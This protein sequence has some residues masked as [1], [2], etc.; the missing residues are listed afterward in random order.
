MLKWRCSYVCEC[1][2]GCTCKCQYTWWLVN[3]W[4]NMQN[5]L[6]V[7][8]KKCLFSFREKKKH[9]KQY[10]TPGRFRNLTVCFPKKKKKKKCKVATTVSV[11]FERVI[12]TG[13]T[14][15]GILNVTTKFLYCQYSTHYQR[16]KN[17]TA[18]HLRCKYGRI[19]N[20][21]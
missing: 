19:W 2:C 20:A 11:D 5:G 21:Q 13:I 1:L 8:I 10:T 17:A 9:S 16:Y 15:K 18:E 14:Y 12:D 7:N 4:N 3:K 6:G